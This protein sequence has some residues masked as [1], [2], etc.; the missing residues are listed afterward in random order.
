MSYAEDPQ[1]NI[2]KAISW[3][4]IIIIGSYAGWWAAELIKLLYVR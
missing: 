4:F 3:I 2:K 1:F